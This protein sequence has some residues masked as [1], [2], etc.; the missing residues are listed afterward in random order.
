MEEG[1]REEG[2]REEGSKKTGSIVDKGEI[3]GLI[4]VPQ[5]ILIQFQNAS[6]TLPGRSQNSETTV[7]ERLQ[8]TDWTDES[9]RM[10]REKCPKG[11]IAGETIAQ[12]G[13]RIKPAGKACF[14]P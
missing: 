9:S 6:R 13:G 10:D 5:S 2:G 8:L 11:K 7:P 12:S 4:Q 1:V 14:S 3:G